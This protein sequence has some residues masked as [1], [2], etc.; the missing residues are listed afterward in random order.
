ELYID[1]LSAAFVIRN[2]GHK[3]ELEFLIMINNCVE[4]W[5][6][7]NIKKNDYAD[8]DDAIAKSGITAPDV[9]DTDYY[10]F[11]MIF[12]TSLMF[13]EWMSETG[14]DRLL[15]K[16][17]ITPGELYAKITNADWMLYSASELAL[18]LGK[19]DIAND[20]NKLRLRVKH[21]IK[22]EL[23]Q[24]IRLK[25]IGRVRARMLWKNSIR[26]FSDMRN[27]PQEKLEK[28]LGSKIAKQLKQDLQESLDKKMRS[29][30]RSFSRQ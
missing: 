30:K 2:L 11:L 14:E 1:P 8:M 27:A 13:N 6:L 29:I 23:L 3:S 20:L 15:D 12:K 22:E 28:I 16:Y 25:G 24:L 18:L 9:W 5:P 21:G 26:N 4:M 7:L 17:G 19:N 10:E